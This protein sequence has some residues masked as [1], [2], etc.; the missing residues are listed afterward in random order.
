MARR[1]RVYFPGA[2]YHVISRGNQKQ[3]IFRDERDFRTFLSYLSEYQARY[4]FHLYAFALMR[5]HC[6]F[7]LEVKEIPLSK[8]MQVLQFRYT[9]Y[10]NKRYRKVGHLFQGR[11]KAIL[12]D[13]EVYLL[14][15]IRYIHLNP[16]R[17][18]MVEDPEEYPWTG[19]RDYLG[20]GEENLIDSDLVLSQFSRKRSLARKQYRRF[21]SDGMDTGHEQKYYQVKDQRYLGED[22][23]V[24]KVEGLNKSHEP[25]YWE[26]SVEKIVEEVIR[27]TSIPRDRLYS[28]TRGRQGAYGRNLVA[29]L[30]RKVA[31]F[32]VKEIAQHFKREPMT[33]SLGVKKVERLLQEDRDFFKKVEIMEMNL[34]EKSKKKYFNTIA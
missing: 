29:Y 30:A 15:L 24:E 17:A 32:R 6:H 8:V 16:V 9:R 20:K 3:T 18:G 5:N 26:V 28:L 14:E 25:S 2:L 10:F 27:G 1:P 22:E 34:S 31:G 7:L 21:V 13:K 11:Y 4:S 23:F 12:C 19:H 33:I